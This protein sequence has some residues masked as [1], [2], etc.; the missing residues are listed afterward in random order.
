MYQAIIALDHAETVDNLPILV[1]MIEQAE[2]HQAWDL[3]AS[4]I[5]TLLDTGRLNAEENN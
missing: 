5:Q 3:A 2:N 4:R 1:D